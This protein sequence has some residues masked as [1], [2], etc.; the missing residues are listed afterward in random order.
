[1]NGRVAGSSNEHPRGLIRHTKL[2]E[3]DPIVIT[4]VAKADAMPC[5]KIVH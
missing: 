3:D 5:D 4:D 2:S 1:M